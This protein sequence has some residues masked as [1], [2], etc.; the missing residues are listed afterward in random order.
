M[1][2]GLS[3]GR[4]GKKVWFGVEGAGCGGLGDR[5]FNKNPLAFSPFAQ[6]GSLHDGEASAMSCSGQLGPSFYGV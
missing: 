5:F 4:V 1:P 3:A 6:E 2:Y